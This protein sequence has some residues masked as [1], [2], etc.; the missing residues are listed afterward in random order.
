MDQWSRPFFQFPR[1][2]FRSLFMFYQ[3][4]ALHEVSQEKKKKCVRK[5]SKKFLLIFVACQRRSSETSIISIPT[6]GWKKKI[7]L[8][9]FSFFFLVLKKLIF[10]QHPPSVSESHRNNTFKCRLRLICMHRCRKFQ[11]AGGHHKMKCST[12]YP[13][14]QANLRPV[15]SWHH[16]HARSHTLTI[17]TY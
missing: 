1:F 16:K 13:N 5:W 14:G 9:M 2:H 15:R 7:V 8:K 12:R 11:I 4:C 17:Y 6:W 10:V 3:R